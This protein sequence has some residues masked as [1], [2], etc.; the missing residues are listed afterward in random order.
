MWDFFQTVRHRQSVRH[1]QNV[2]ID[3]EDLHGVLEMGIVAPSA[4]DL[5]AYH[6]VVVQT[7]PLRQRLAE[8]SGQTFLA[9]APLNIV[10][11]AAP[12]RSASEFGEYCRNL[13]CIQDAT[14][15]ATY[16]QLA[17]VAAG[18]GSAWASGFKEEAVRSLLELSSQL[19]PVA[20]LALGYPA[21]FPEPTPRRKLSELV[22]YR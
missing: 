10:V 11:C 3:A 8:L 12:E 7:E 6:L 22:S 9:E 20:I 14:I 16:I 21:E 4:G 19:R 17:A 13:F 15:A 2:P 18:L 1:Y 5:Q